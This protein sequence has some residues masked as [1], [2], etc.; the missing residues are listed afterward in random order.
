VFLRERHCHVLPSG[1]RLEVNTQLFQ[2]TLPLTPELKDQ[3]LVV[4][5][6]TGNC[7]WGGAVSIWGQSVGQGEGYGEFTGYMQGS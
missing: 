4:F 1:W 6:S 7:D 5:Q 3:E 2:A